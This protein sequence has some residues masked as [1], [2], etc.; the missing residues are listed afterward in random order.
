MNW[1]IKQIEISSFKAFK[2]INLD[3][4]KSDLLTL[5][6]PNGYGKTSVFDAIE[7]L[8]TG[9]IKRIQNLFT[10]LMTRNKSNYDDNLF[11]NNRSEEKDLYIKIEFYNGEKKLTLARHTP[12]KSF[13]TKSNNRADKF[14]HFT[15]YEL[16]SFESNSF[17]SNNKRENDYL[18]SIFG[19]NF[20]ENFSF[21]NYLEQGQNKLLHTRIDERK[22]ALG[23]LFNT[24]DIK[25]EID[26][27][28]ITLSKITRSINNSER[29]ERLSSLEKE[30]EDLKEINSVTDEFIEF[31]KI[32]T[33]EPQPTW[34]KEEPFPIFNNETYN[35]FIESVQKLIELIPLKNAIQIRDANE[36]IEAYINRYAFSLTNLAKFG[37]D[38]NRLDSLDRTKEQVDLLDYAVSITQKGASLI[39]IEQARK[40][41]SLQPDRLEWF[42][43]QIKQRDSIKSRITANESSVTELKIL[44][45]KMVEEHGKLYPTDKH[46]PLCGHDWQTHELM[47][48]A[49]EEKAK[50][51]EGILSQ[52]GQS[53]VTLT[54]SMNSELASLELV[55]QE[56][57]KLVK[58]QYNEALHKALK[59]VR[60]DLP[61]LQL[62]AKQLKERD[63]N[64]D[65]QFNEDIVT[66]NSRVDNLLMQIRAK[67][68]Q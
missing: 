1:K 64:I 14:K 49:I 43:K 34:D 67:K 51:L 68:N 62:L 56:R 33:I 23:N 17:T 52:D 53:L 6:G 32:S 66:V 30:L 48:S 4:E 38:I 10:T 39:S 29:V 44:K 5:D 18:D 40:L 19:N 21:L 60:V 15:L 27:C 42:E 31:K 55:I 2:N 57:L 47:L 8:L 54:S 65:F 24:S 46:C 13:K 50:R 58:P 7:L 3:L 20:R 63:L 36:K 26:N 12:S 28:N 59:Q 41:P 11:W 45:S 61:A 25:N 35:I 16:P 9:Q 37:N 22:E